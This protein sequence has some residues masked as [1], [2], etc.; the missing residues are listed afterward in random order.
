VSDSLVTVPTGAARAEW[1]PLLELA[2][3]PV[4]LAR[5]L[6]DGTLYG[7][8]DDDGGPRAANLVRVDHATAE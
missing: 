2:D 8:V 7:S 5:Y 4:P 3:E 6:D 1:A